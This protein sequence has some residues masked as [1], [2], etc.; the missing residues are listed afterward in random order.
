MSLMSRIDRLNRCLVDP[1]AKGARAVLLALAA[2]LLP[3]L[4]RFALLGIVSEAGFLSYLPSVLLAAILLGWGHAIVVAL[5]SAVLA[6][7]LF[8]GPPLQF[9]E[10]ADDI[11]GFIVFLLSSALIVGLVQV[12]RP[13]LRDR[14]QPPEQFSNGVI[15]SL[16]GGDAWARSSSCSCSV[17]L[18]PQDEVAGSMED[19]LAQLEVGKR[20]TR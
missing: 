20:L 18:G 13:V 2:L 5:G 17:R 10:G 12:I 3:T 4:V 15:F 8:V 9:L 16:E 14:Q 7:L 6:D 1:P 19:F 11:F